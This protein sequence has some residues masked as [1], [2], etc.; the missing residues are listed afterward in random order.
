MKSPDLIIW[1]P[2]GSSEIGPDVTRGFIGCKIQNGLE[3]V[4]VFS[5]THPKSTS[6]EWTRA[7]SVWPSGEVVMATDW[8]APPVEREC[9]QWSDKTV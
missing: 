4:S 2:C 6:P 9:K 8:Q 1:N 7:I 3:S 5:P